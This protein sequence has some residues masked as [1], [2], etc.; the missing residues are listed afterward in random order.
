MRPPSRQKFL[1][2]NPGF[3]S[4]FSGMTATQNLLGIRQLSSCKPLPISATITGQLVNTPELKL[5]FSHHSIPPH[6]RGNAF[7]IAHDLFLDPQLL[8][9]RA[10]TAMATVGNDSISRCELVL[11]A[12][13]KLSSQPKLSCSNRGHATCSIAWFNQLIGFQTQHIG[14]S[15]T[16]SNIA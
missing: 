10:A 9:C 6:N 3:W 2:L 7:S 4:V 14:R 5:A 15:W 13:L 16:S 12:I 1:T 8:C 11:R